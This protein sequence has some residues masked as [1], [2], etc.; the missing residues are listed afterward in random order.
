MP[1]TEADNG[2]GKHKTIRS[3]CREFVTGSPEQA[4][5][6][7]GDEVHQRMKNTIPENEKANIQACLLKTT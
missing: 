7:D 5:S 2:I 3:W 1:T 6:N 4:K